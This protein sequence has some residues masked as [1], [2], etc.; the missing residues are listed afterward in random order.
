M[1]FARLGAVYGQQARQHNF[2][3]GGEQDAQH[4]LPTATKITQVWGGK[5]LL[6]ETAPAQLVPGFARFP[7]DLLF[8]NNSCLTS[9]PRKPGRRSPKLSSGS[10]R[11]RPTHGRIS[12]L[13]ASV[14]DQSC[15]GKSLGH[16]FLGGE[17]DPRGLFWDA[18]VHRVVLYSCRACCPT[19]CSYPDSSFKQRHFQGC[20]SGNE[21]NEQ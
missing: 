6:L 16:V 21:S 20:C 8:P 18:S 3:P 13:I 10:T 11:Q 7:L 4:V 5:A 19:F 15:T 1:G 17:W 2:M 9:Q 12:P 14:Q